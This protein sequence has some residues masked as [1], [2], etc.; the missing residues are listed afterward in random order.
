MDA[1]G[2]NALSWCLNKG[3]A[4]ADVVKLLLDSGIDINH[5]D[6]EGCL[7]IDYVVAAG[8]MLLTRLLLKHASGIKSTILPECLVDL[9]LS[10]G[11]AAFHILKEADLVKQ[12][13]AYGILLTFMLANSTKEFSSICECS[14]RVNMT[15]CLE[16]LSTCD[17]IMLFD[18]AGVIGDLCGLHPHIIQCLQP[19]L[20]IGATRN[21]THLV[22]LLLSQ[23]IY[24]KPDQPY[25]MRCLVNLAVDHGSY[26][27]AAGITTDDVLVTG[28]DNMVI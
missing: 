4:R 27:V 6:K 28:T 25:I 10:F 19:L 20:K 16:C 12:K 3:I 8:D 17:E 13:Q 23:S 2:R 14:K 18:T 15:E 24:K 11:E 1:S 9:W 21:L 22:K 26:E 7:P 5:K